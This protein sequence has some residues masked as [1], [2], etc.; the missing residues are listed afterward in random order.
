MVY[1]KDSDILEPK[2][3]EKVELDKKANFMQREKLRLSVNESNLF[4][5]IRHGGDTNN[6]S[7]QIQLLKLLFCSLSTM[8]ADSA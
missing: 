4:H 3:N 5:Y 7:T 2:F 8:T 1:I 6:V